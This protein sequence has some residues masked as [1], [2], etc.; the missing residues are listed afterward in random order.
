[1]LL[2][3]ALALLSLGL[4]VTL[5]TRPELYTHQ[6][7]AA[8]L[9]L[10]VFTLAAVARLQSLGVRYAVVERA[11]F[12][13]ELTAPG[14]LEFNQRDVAIVQARANGFVQR[15]YGRAPGDVVRAGA[16]IA[17]LLVPTW[18]G[19]QA[20]YLAVRRTGDAAL[21]AAARQRLRLLGMPEGLIEAVAGGE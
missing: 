12:A 9:G 4:A 20:E 1:M 16:P 15:V 5:R 18:G 19:A 11:S 7:I 10:I 3:A 6:A 2:P 21:E 13:D 14:M 17:D 8:A